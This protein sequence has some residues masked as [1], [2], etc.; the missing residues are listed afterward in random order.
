MDHHQKDSKRV[1][2]DKEIK[3]LDELVRGVYAKHDLSEGYTFNKESFDKDFF[4]SIPLQKG[5]LSCREILNGEKLTKDI[6]AS[7]PLYDK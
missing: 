4:M 2:T 3:Y 7:D 6:K 5:Q 1:I